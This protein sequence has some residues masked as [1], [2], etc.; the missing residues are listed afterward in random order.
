MFSN[1]KSRLG[2]IGELFAFLKKKKMWWVMPMMVMLLVFTALIIFA[3]SSALAPFIYT[4][5]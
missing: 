5:F 2:I 3:Q 4:L 1:I